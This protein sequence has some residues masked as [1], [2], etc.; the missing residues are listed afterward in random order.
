MST[1]G[2]GDNIKR[3]DGVAHQLTP[4]GF[5]VT[6][7]LRYGATI[8][9]GDEIW[10]RFEGWAIRRLKRQDEGA[11]FAA[12]VLDGGGGKIIGVERDTE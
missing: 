9:E 2:S 12:V 3:S 10:S 4:K 1:N 6:V 5:W 7:L 11:G 8:E